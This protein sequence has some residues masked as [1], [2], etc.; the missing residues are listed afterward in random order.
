MLNK[1]GYAETYDPAIC[2][3]E[4]EPTKEEDQNEV[5]FVKKRRELTQL[6]RVVKEVCGISVNKFKSKPANSVYCRVTNAVSPSEIWVQDIVD[7]QSC[8]EQFHENFCKTY[9][10]QLSEAESSET[11]ALVRAEW[12]V[13]DLAVMRKINTTN[14]GTTTNYYRCKIHQVLPNG[15]YQVL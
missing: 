11:P 3:G 6:E 14:A 7:A 8:F 12:R 5:K 9:E 13:G 4:K 2:E 10:A 1:I 15:H